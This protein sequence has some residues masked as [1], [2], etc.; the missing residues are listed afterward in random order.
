MQQWHSERIIPLAGSLIILLGLGITLTQSATSQNGVKTLPIL[1]PSLPYKASLA[2]GQTLLQLSNTGSG[3]AIEGDSTN[4]AA[5][6]GQSGSGGS[7]GVWGLNT[8]GGFG[9]IGF[10]GSSTNAAVWGDNNSSGP[11][12]LGQSGSGF[13]VLGESTSTYG[14]YAQGGNFGVGGVGNSVGVSGTSTSG[15][16]VDGYSTNSYGVQGYS[17]HQ[18]GVIGSNGDTNNYGELGTGYEGVYGYSNNAYGGLFG[19]I[20]GKGVYG[21]SS[22]SIGVYGSSTNNTGV[23]GDG[24]DLGVYGHGQG[25][26]TGVYGDSVGTGSAIVG[27]NIARGNYGLMGGPV[28]YNSATY[29]AGVFGSG[30]LSGTDDGTLGA[31]VMGQGGFASIYGLPSNSYAGYFDGTTFVAG[32]FAASAKYF[33]IDHPLDPANKYLSHSCIESSEYMNLYRGNVLLDSNGLAVV[34]VPDWFEALN[35]NYS[36]QLTCVGGFAPVYIA[37]ELQNHQFLI[38]GGRS[39]MKVCWQIMG[40]RQDAFARAHPL[41]VEQEKPVGERGRYLHPREYGLPDSLG[42]HRAQNLDPITQA[43]TLDIQATALPKQAPVPTK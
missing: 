13:G 2:S 36:Y 42:I 14:V 19:S 3:S 9:V 38:A 6:I 22:N 18:V 39:G 15:L 29:H 35:K 4:T 28:Y 37:R 26:G 34:T 32:V 41:Q 16:G 40:E 20:N 30:T 8:G 1:I 27:R 25:S 5:V 10:N 12:V 24:N 23:E 31:G 43:Q 21:S 7:S 17:G 33:K 11:G